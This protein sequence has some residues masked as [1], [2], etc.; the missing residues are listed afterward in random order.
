[1]KDENLK[2]KIEKEINKLKTELS[3]EGIA[4]T[5]KAAIETLL[6]SIG[7]LQAV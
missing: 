2:V 7:E 5:R 6:D 1:M 4:D 3:N